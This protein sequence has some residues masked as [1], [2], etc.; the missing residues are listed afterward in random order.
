MSLAVVQ[1][2]DRNHTTPAG[3]SS[4]MAFEPALNGCEAVWKATAPPA[5]RL[6][7]EYCTTHAVSVDATDDD[8]VP[9]PT[10]SIPEMLFMT[11]AL[12]AVVIYFG[13]LPI[14]A[15]KVRDGHPP[16][17]AW[18]TIVM[19]R[20]KDDQR[21]PEEFAAT[22]RRRLTLTAWW[23]L[24][25]GILLFGATLAQV[26]GDG[27]ASIRYLPLSMAVMF[28]SQGAGSLLARRTLDAPADRQSSNG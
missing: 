1:S 21:T 22:Y 13:A 24:P 7:I 16:T 14:E 12:A 19:R 17:N 27:L 5:T 23:M 28:T 10:P 25:C 15:R 26:L 11:L 4:V 20:S 6:K 9:L 3:A 2:S 18:S 8:G